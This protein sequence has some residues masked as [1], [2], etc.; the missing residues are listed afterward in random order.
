MYGVK[1]VLLAQ[2]KLLLIHSIVAGKILGH[3]TFVLLMP[4]HDALV[5]TAPLLVMS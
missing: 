3:A 2:H 1:R 4:V 5:A